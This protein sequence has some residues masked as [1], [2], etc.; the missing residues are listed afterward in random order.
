MNIVAICGI[1]VLSAI[2][3]VALKKYNPEYAVI[4]SLLCGVLIL[5]LILSKISPAISQI[6]NLISA[7]N[8]SYDN[9]LILFK[10]LGICF[11]AQFSSDVCKDAGE[12][13]LASKIE[14]AGKITIILL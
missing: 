3:C 14:I 12:M 8:I 11:L 1:C 7:T 2:L 9:G 5:A 10:S 6:K 13:A 4:V